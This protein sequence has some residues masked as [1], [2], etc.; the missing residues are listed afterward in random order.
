[1]SSRDRGSAAVEFALVLPVL[2]LVIFGIVDFGRLLTA[3]LI[4]TRAVQEGARATALAGTAEGT[5]R[6]ASATAGL[7]AAAGNLDVVITPCAGSEASPSTA[8]AVSDQPAL[9]DAPALGEA[10]V[11]VTHRFQFVTPVGLFAGL[12]GAGGGLDLTAESVMPAG[13]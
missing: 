5:T 9:D 8:P 12:G 13:V 1:M 11:K 6:V 7:G 10:S 4:L 2:L 3:K